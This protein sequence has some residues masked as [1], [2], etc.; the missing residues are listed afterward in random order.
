MAM[1]LTATSEFECSA[2]TFMKEGKIPGKDIIRLGQEEANSA[3]L[4]NATNQ[5]AEKSGENDIVFSTI[6]SHG[7]PGGFG[8]VR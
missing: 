4:E 7:A 6:C 1:G 3:S 5:I 8:D 2:T